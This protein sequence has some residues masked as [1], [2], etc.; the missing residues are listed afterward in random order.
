VYCTKAILYVDDVD[1]SQ[2]V[3]VLLVGLGIDDVVVATTFLFSKMLLRILLL[4]RTI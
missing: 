1:N 2:V 4:G 3:E